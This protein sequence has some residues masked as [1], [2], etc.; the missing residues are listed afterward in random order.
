MTCPDCKGQKRIL[1]FSSYVNCEKCCND[2]ILDYR[3]VFKGDESPDRMRVRHSDPCFFYIFT[4]KIDVR[5]CTFALFDVVSVNNNR[6]L[7][8]FDKT[9]GKFS[10][11]K[12]AKQLYAHDPFYPTEV[13][14]RFELYHVE[15][16]DKDCIV[17]KKVS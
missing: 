1:L 11:K 10:D 16:Q 2:T 17:L 5:E 3:E 8:C 14:D 15:K 12:Y 9:L 6:V 4:N 13:L 7:S